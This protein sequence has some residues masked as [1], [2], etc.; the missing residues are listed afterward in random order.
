MSV[1]LARRLTCLAFTIAAT[2]CGGSAEK[3]DGAGATGSDGSQTATSGSTTQSGVG[4]AGTGTSVGTG[5]QTSAGGGRVSTSA[6]DAGGSLGS[7]SG[8]ASSGGAAS[9]TGGNTTDGMGEAG[10]GGEGGCGGCGGS[11]GSVEVPGFDDFI[12]RSDAMGAY[13]GLTV[14]VAFDQ[15]VTVDSRS[16]NRSDVISSGAFEVMWSQ[17]FDRNTFGS[18]VLLYVDVDGNAVCDDDVDEAWWFFANNLFNEG[19]P[20]IAEFDPDPDGMTVGL[21]EISCDQFE[22]GL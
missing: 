4:G 6:S 17:G 15:N 13:E 10:E 16:E 19:E 5:A 18:Y 3:G 12:I 14:Y 8:A 11:G 9:G 22:S 20:A 7:G 2:G 1:M 21:D